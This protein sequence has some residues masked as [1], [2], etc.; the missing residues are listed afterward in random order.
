MVTAPI[1]FLGGCHLNRCTFIHAGDKLKGLMRFDSDAALVV[2][3][4]AQRGAGI[5]SA[6]VQRQLPQPW[7]DIVTSYLQALMHSSKGERLAACKEF[8]CA[9]QKLHE[10]SAQR[11]RSFDFLIVATGNGMRGGC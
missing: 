2:M 9:A 1:D 11:M 4:L 10:E 8:R 5:P 6:D 3:Q 7:A